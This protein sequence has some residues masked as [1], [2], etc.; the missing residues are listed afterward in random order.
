[1]D[2]L[3]FRCF[4]SF[5]LNSI[6]EH[7]SLYYLKMILQITNENNILKRT[8]SKSVSIDCIETNTEAKENEHTA[9]HRNAHDKHLFVMLI[10]E[11]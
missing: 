6:E 2:C 7:L 9:L 4:I 10:S 11:R 3:Y 1:M 8:A 5:S